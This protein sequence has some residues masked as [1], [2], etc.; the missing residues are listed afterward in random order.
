MSDLDDEYDDEYDDDLDEDEIGAA[1]NRVTGARAVAVVQYLVRSLAEDPDAV[2]VTVE[3]HR[4]SAEITVR[5]DPGDVGR[6]IG[7]RGR[8]IQAIRQVA[9]AAGAG[10]GARVGVEIAE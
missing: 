10:E 1:G 7:R 6:I 2:D 9:R 5:T 3:E 4:G 8:V